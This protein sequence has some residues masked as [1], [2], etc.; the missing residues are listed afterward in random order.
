MTIFTST[1]ALYYVVKIWS[2]FIPAIQFSQDLNLILYVNY[3]NL[4]E[5]HSF[6]Y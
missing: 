4:V 5:M 6:K 3:N 1:Y 2:L